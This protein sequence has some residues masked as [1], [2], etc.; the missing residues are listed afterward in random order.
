MDKIRL[1][2]YNKEKHKELRC[3]KKESLKSETKEITYGNGIITHRLLKK[4]AEKAAQS[5]NIKQMYEDSLEDY[6][7]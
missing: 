1:L 4:Y 6:I 7:T 2:W 3:M 5:K